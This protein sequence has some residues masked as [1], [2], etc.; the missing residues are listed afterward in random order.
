[1][2]R[3]RMSPDEW[4]A[5]SKASEARIKELRDRVEKI[6]AELEAS[7]AKRAQE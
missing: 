7:R 1:M 6:K 2:K 3:K 4:R 5:W